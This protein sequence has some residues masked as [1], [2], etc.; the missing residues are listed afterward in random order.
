M[1]FL[2]IGH[3]IT[4]ADGRV[5]ERQDIVYLDIP[6]RFRPP[7]PVAPPPDP[8]FAEPVVMSEAR[9]FRFSAATFNAH[10]IHHDL[11]YAREVEKYPALVIHA[12]LQAMLLVEAG[13]RHAGRM[14]ARFS[15]RGVHPM[16]HGEALRLMGTP[17][18]APQP[19]A[20]GGGSIALCTVAE[21][22]HQGL[23]AKLEW[24]T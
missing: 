6:D 8:V 3:D 12:P 18:P 4:G 7:Q 20:A 1:I 15:V 11:A 24:A 21:A 17:T 23:R 13:A 10:R 16:F 2:R 9:L 5:A 14:L 19:G 22:G